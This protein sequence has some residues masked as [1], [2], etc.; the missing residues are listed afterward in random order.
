NSAG[1]KRRS[2]A[3]RATPRCLSGAVAQ[4][5]ERLVR[6]EEVGGP[7]PLGPPPGLPKMDQPAKSWPPA[8]VEAVGAGALS[9]S[10][11]TAGNAGFSRWALSSIRRRTPG[12]GF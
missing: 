10:S 4:L 3:Q 7:T 11:V 6:N 8:G 9:P 5:G 12:P 1:P 2:P